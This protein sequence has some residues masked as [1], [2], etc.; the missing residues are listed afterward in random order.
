MWTAEKERR[1]AEMRI[2]GRVVAEEIARTPSN[3]TYGCYVCGKQERWS[4][5]WQQYGSL[6]D[7]D[8]FGFYIAV[9]SQPCRE[10]IPDI[11]TVY[12]AEVAELG[13]RPRYA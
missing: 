4:D 13:S 7:M 6:R 2:R 10:K 12:D 9:C 5:S 3:R 8:D 11:E 1:A